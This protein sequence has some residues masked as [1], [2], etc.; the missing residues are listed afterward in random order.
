MVAHS[1]CVK[2]I[3]TELVHAVLTEFNALFQM[4][5]TWTGLYICITIMDWNMITSKK[6]NRLK[7]K[8]HE[9]KLKRKKKT[10]QKI[11]FSQWLMKSGN[12]PLYSSTM[13]IYSNIYTVWIASVFNGL[14][15]L[16][17]NEW[18]FF[19]HVP[20]TNIKLK[21]LWMLFRLL[22]CNGRKKKVVEYN[23]CDEIQ[24]FYFKY[25]LNARQLKSLMMTNKKKNSFKIVCLFFYIVHSIDIGIT[26][27]LPELEALLPFRH[28]RFLWE[29]ICFP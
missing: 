24:L 1:L 13:T 26:H 4:P 18:I 5:S 12:C 10:M 15:K 23:H 14:L 3:K 21:Q 22:T 28:I 9:L 17:S 27:A 20:T 19:F 8:K 6:M 11:I 25:A 7:N 16:S 2:L 29:S